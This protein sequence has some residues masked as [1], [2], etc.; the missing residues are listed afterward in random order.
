MTTKHNFNIFMIFF[1]KLSPLL[2][3]SVNILGGLSP[4]T[5]EIKINKWDLMC[6]CTC[7]WVTMM[8]K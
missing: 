2:K 3:K 4:K 5:K 6:I 7:N 8:Y 1:V